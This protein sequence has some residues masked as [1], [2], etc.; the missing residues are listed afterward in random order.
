MSR[1]GWLVVLG[2]LVVVG[3]VASAAPGGI[4]QR[5]DVE[6]RRSL[7]EAFPNYPGAVERDA[8]RYEITS[9][10]VGTGDYGLR[11]IYELPAEA[12]A[13]EVIGF[14]VRGLPHGW[15]LASDELCAGVLQQLPGPPMMT[16]SAPTTTDPVTPDEFRLLETRSRVTAFTPDGSPL[17]N[18]DVDG[19]SFTLMRTGEAKY[20]VADQP[21]FACGSETSDPAAAEFDR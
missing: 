3:F 21:L 1:R 19:V 13:A 17:S 8:E 7:Y 16:P 15:E 14:Y 10:G 12:T 2:G 4:S 20:L 11:V 9:D 5:A 18:D 6:H